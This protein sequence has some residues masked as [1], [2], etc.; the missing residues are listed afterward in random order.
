MHSGKIR[1][2][3]LDASFLA[4]ES[5][6][7]PMH[8]GALL[9]LD[10]AITLQQARETIER[11]LTRAARL[12]TRLHNGAPGTV[13]TLEPDS[14]FKLEH[15]LRQ[16]PVPPPYKAR[17]VAELAGRL[18][19]PAL[20]RYR[21]LW[22]MFLLSDGGHGRAV[23]GKLHHCVADGIAGVDV[24][25]A[26]F[27][28]EQSSGLA[29][30]TSRYRRGVANPEEDKDN[31][32]ASPDAEAISTIARIMELLSRPQAAREQFGNLFNAAAMVAT[33][34]FGAAQALPFN[35]PLS[36]SRRIGWFEIDGVALNA[37]KRRF[38][39]TVNDVVLTMV[40]GGVRTYLRELGHPTRKLMLRTLI[41]VSIRRQR[42]GGRTGNQVSGLVAPLPLAIAGAPR[43]LSEIV[44][45]TRELRS[46]GQ[47]ATLARAVETVGNLTPWLVP[48]LGSMV[49]YRTIDL[50]CSS[51]PGP[52]HPLEIAGQRVETIVPLVPIPEGVWLGFG[53]MTYAGRLCIGINADAALV[54]DLRPVLIGLKQAYAQLCR[55]A[56][57]HGES[58][59]S[60]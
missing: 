19:A 51:V 18:F 5:S 2:S 24:L 35:G 41:P 1:L 60:G 36:N 38:G 33:G 14:S 16:V 27:G 29:I 28:P 10:G 6:T 15:H 39:C 31:Q 55:V 57:V 58:K 56:E 59:M 53:A 7:A 47:A 37:I 11:G 20:R 13:P 52:R 40:T 48:V 42:P 8:T 12:T 50:I 9:L 21:P 22:E 30:A 17:Q 49:F 4:L 32:A 46:S 44:R 3:A 45:V 54:G 25:E 43:R 34:M 26:L 23:L